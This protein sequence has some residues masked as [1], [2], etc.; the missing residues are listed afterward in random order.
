MARRLLICGACCSSELPLEY[1][2]TGGLLG[3]K[4]QCPWSFQQTAHQWAPP[5]SVPWVQ[6]LAILRP[7]SATITHA[8][9]RIWA[10]PWRGSG[11]VGDKRIEG[12]KGEKAQTLNSLSAKRNVAP[13]GLRSVGLYLFCNDVDGII[14]KYRTPRQGNS[15]CW[16]SRDP[17]TET[18]C[19]EHDMSDFMA[20]RT[21]RSMRTN[22]LDQQKNQTKFQK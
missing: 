11:W 7:V 5:Y 19:E 18:H 4:M 16:W 6:N 14:S 22:I 2:L 9:D 20:L 15:T 3:M 8:G 21:I 17:W 10:D 1:R 13:A 12:W